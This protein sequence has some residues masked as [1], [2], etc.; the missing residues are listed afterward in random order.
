[1]GGVEFEIA[2]ANHMRRGGI[3]SKV[4]AICLDRPADILH[5]LLA[6]GYETHRNIGADMV[7]DLL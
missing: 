7:M 6:K 2:E 3:R 5:R 4:D 1:V